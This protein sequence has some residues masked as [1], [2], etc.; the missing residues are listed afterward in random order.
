MGVT[1]NAFVVE[2]FV[3]ELAAAAGKDP[4]AFRRKLPTKAPRA[5]AVLDLA[6]AKAGLGQ[7]PA[8]GKGRG[9]AIAFGFGTYV[10]QVAEVAV[11]EDGSVRVERVVC[12]VDCGTVVNPDTVV[13]QMQ[14]GIIYGLTA[15]LSGEITRHEPADGRLGG[16]SEAGCGWGGSIDTPLAGPLGPCVFP[17]D[18]FQEVLATLLDAAPN[19]PP[20]VVGHPK[21]DRQADRGRWQ[22]RELSARQHSAIADSSLRSTGM[23]RNHNFCAITFQSETSLRIDGKV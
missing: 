10:A 23:C 8:A 20:S 4:V 14:G 1:H 13:A 18:D 9:V 19:L 16:M 17:T 15:A 2:G 5:L 12:A 21:G 6:A 7:P 3:D 22:M 11:A